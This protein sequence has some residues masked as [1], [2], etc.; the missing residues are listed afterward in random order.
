MLVEIK[1]VQSRIYIG[2]KF[3]IYSAYPPKIDQEKKLIAFP[4]AHMMNCFYARYLTE[5]FEISMK[6]SKIS[7]VFTDCDIANIGFLSLKEK[8]NKRFVYVEDLIFNFEDVR[9]ETPDDTK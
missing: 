4:K 7:V 8:D 3:V 5:T 6:N 9:Q 2:D 1:D